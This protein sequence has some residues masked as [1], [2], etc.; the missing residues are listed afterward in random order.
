MFRMITSILYPRYPCWLPHLE[1]ISDKVLWLRRYKLSSGFAFRP[2][3][4]LLFRYW[5]KTVVCTILFQ[6]FVSYLYCG[7]CFQ[8]G[9]SICKRTFLNN[10]DVRKRKKAIKFYHLNRLHDTNCTRKEL[11]IILWIVLKQCL[12]ECQS[13]MEISKG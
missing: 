2:W 12:P 9:L 11:K 6:L 1:T 4:I 13:P 3:H 10:Y 5:K 7:V 8:P